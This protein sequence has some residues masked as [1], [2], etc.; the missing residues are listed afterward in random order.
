MTI[1]HYSIRLSG[2]REHEIVIDKP[3][4]MDQEVTLTVRG[5]VIEVKDTTNNDGT[6]NRCYTIRGE[7]AEEV[8][9]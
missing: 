3:L 9:E 7:I 5:Q 4:S 8:K 1:D 6:V 2:K